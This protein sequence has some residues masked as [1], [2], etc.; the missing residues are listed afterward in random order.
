MTSTPRHDAGGKSA[1]IIGAGLGG[2]ALAIRLQAAGVTTILLEARDRPGGLASHWQRDGFTFDAGPTA[3]TDPDSF[4]ELWRLTGH[5]IAG[6]VVLEPVRPFYKLS[7]PDGSQFDYSHDEAQFRQEVARFG[8]EELAGY[9]RFLEYSAGLCREVYPT[10]GSTPFLDFAAMAKAGPMLAQYQ[11]WRSVY[12]T[13]ARF[14]RDEKLRQVL[15]FHTLLIGGNPMTASALYAL[16]P[17]LE[18]EC[19]LWYPR[20][21]IGRLVAALVAQFERIGGTLRLGDPVTR[22]ETMGD[23]ATA[24]ETRN[25]W[26][27]EADAVISNADLMH[28]YRDLLGDHPRGT[29]KAEKLTRKSWTPSFFA[30]HF[31][32]RG[33]WP[34]I[35]QHMLLFGPRYEELLT[36]IYQH[37]VLSGDLALYLHHPTITDPALAPE[38]CSVFR[39]LVPVPHRG[40]LPIDWEAMA[41]AYADRILN[42]IGRRLIPDIRARIMTRFTWTP[43]DFERDTHLFRGSTGALE[44]LLSQSAW[45][46]P[47]NRDDVIRNFYLVG[48]GTHP[49][50]GVPGVLS[51]ARI[52]ARLILE[53]LA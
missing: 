41:P 39:A 11:A 12:A 19:G 13:V 16:A 38:G 7:W 23:R 33:T 32:I 49:G 1:I 22:I 6:D 4:A 31:G 8:S 44:P 43:Q 5:D 9:E 37:G 45:F 24:V 18:K 48:A 14:V 35:P 34:G 26:R 42:E 15:S 3:I 51:G 36:D 52:T 28:S 47:H 53:D 10:L 25:G 46:R 40:K 21:G 29:A 30:L 20:G 17:K 27:G 50:A 2:L